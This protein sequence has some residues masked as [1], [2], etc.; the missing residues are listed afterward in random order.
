MP[1][2]WQNPLLIDL[3][4]CKWGLQGALRQ[5]HCRPVGKS[6]SMRG[7]RTNPHLS[8]WPILYHGTT[9]SSYHW[10]WVRKDRGS[11]L[12]SSLENTNTNFTLSILLYLCEGWMFKENWVKKRSPWFFLNSTKIFSWGHAFPCST[13]VFIIKNICLSGRG[14]FHECHIY[15]RKERIVFLRKFPWGL[16]T[17]VKFFLRWCFLQPLYW[18][19]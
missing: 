12:M 15:P 7:H 9:Y 16:F 2:Q 8:Q 5:G 6:L 4:E 13:C 3:V 1:F 17:F 10:P 18:W 14:Y 11:S 19:L